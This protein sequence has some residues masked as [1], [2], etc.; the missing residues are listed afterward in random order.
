MPHDLIAGD[1]V[2]VTRLVDIPTP[3]RSST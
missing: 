2:M 1:V 3:P